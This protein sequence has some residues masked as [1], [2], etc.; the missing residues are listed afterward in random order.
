MRAIKKYR[1]LVLAIAISLAWHLFWISALKVVASPTPS[2]SPGL[3]RVSFLGPTSFGRGMEMKLSPKKSSLLEK[4]Y[5]ARLEG[6]PLNWAGIEA[7]YIPY[8][9]GSPVEDTATG[10]INSSVGGPKSEPDNTI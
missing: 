3:G 7:V 2:R 5:L 6:V 10:L 8:D 9:P 4:R 1:V